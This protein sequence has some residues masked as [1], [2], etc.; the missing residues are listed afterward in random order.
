MTKLNCV[1]SPKV[2]SCFEKNKLKTAP[3]WARHKPLIDCL[4]SGITVCSF[5]LKY[6]CN[7]VHLEEE[8]IQ[9]GPA[10][11]HQYSRKFRKY[12]ANVFKFTLDAFMDQFSWSLWLILITQHS[13]TCCTKCEQPCGSTIWPRSAAATGIILF[14]SYFIHI[15]TNCSFF[16]PLYSPFPSVITYHFS[17]TGYAAHTTSTQ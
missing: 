9:S 8:Q 17:P 14:I 6:I 3:Q 4:N 12:L 5:C 10:N 15:L 1:S 13:K 7:D 11:K 2:S 16:S